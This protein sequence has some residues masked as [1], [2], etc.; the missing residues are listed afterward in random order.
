MLCARQEASDTILASRDFLFELKLDGVRIIADKDDGRVSLWYRKARDATESYEEVADAV[1]ALD[2]P[3]VVLD[4]EV[5]AF[6]EQGRPDFQ[7]LG[8][9]IQRMGRQ[10]AARTV[11]VAY[12]VF[13]VLALGDADVRSLP[14]EERRAVLEKIV[15]EKGTHIR[16]APTFDDGHTLFGFCREHGLE[17]VVA[18][19]RGSKYRGGERSA[20]WLKIKCELEADLVVI[21]WTEGEGTRARMGALDLGVYED[22]KLVV[23]GS[24]GSG[25]SEATIDALLPVLRTLEVERPVA[26]GKYLK[27]RGRRHVRPEVVVSVRYGG[28][29]SDGLLR[30]PVFRGVRPD[31]RPEDCV[32][33]HGFGPEGA[34]R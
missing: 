18:K 32:L 27:K 30:H 10:G 4:G 14:L 6:D 21:G 17:G 3:R 28:I 16:L 2:V 12:V 34:A 8:T 11:P 15:P 31:M 7:R 25:L 13:D 22:G 5:V 33:R 19:R 23:R 9:R 26:T 20:D 1:R 24:V 29:T